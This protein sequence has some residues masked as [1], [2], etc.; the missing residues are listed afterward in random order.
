M[1]IRSLLLGSV[2]AAGLSTGA[3]AADLGVLTSLDVCD[4]LGL[5]GLTISSDTNC[6]QI[7]GEVKYEFRW[8]NFRHD[9]QIGQ[10]PGGPGG[11]I[12]GDGVINVFS[13]LDDNPTHY[14]WY[15][16]VE[17]WLKFVATADSDMGPAKAVIKIK[18]VDEQRYTDVFERDPHDDTGGVIL[19]E[20]YVAIGDSTVIMVG[21]K[22]SIANFGD[23]EPFNFLQLFGYTE[24][25]NGVLF[26]NNDDL[27]IT[28]GHVIQITTDLGNGVSASLGLENIEGDG[29]MPLAAEEAGTLVGVLAYAGDGV[30][31]HLTAFAGGILDGTVEMFGIHAGATGEFDIFKIRAAV[32]YVH[33]DNRWDAPGQ[34]V[35]QYNAL[36]AMLTAS[37]TFDIFTIAASGEYSHFEDVDAG[38]NEDGFGFG[39]SIGAA[40]TDGISVNLGGRWFSTNFDNGAAPDSDGDI[41]QVALQVIAELTETIKVTGEVG[42]YFSEEFIDNDDD[43]VA[44]GALELAWAPGGGFTSSIKGEANTAHGYRVTFKAAKSFE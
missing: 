31:A 38:T 37:A 12:L 14:D 24:V 9:R 5:S 26:D 40:V 35:D 1:K 25:D 8:G 10:V 36:H 29:D 21:K 2:A 34:D 42:A 33:N 20:A 19:D 44:Y 3:Y 11:G 16:K 32:G 43:A 13:E 27:R 15:S 4:A 17:A 6:L 7:T 23:S 28:G 41:A 22:G 30:T 39:A 18:E